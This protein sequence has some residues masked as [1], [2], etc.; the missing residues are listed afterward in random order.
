MDWQG[1]IYCT[2]KIDFFLKLAF[3]CIEMHSTEL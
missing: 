2:F 1:A 3:W